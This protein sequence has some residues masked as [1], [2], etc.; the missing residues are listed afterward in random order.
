[1]KKMIASDAYDT[2]K[3]MAIT[4]E[5]IT[6][7]A[8]D[9][10]SI[11]EFGKSLFQIADMFKDDMTTVVRYSKPVDEYGNVKI[12]FQ[13]LKSKAK[14]FEK[15]MKET[16]STLFC[17]IT[18]AK[19]AKSIIKFINSLGVK[20]QDE[21]NLITKS[22]DYSDDIKNMLKDGYVSIKIEYDNFTFVTLCPT[23]DD[24]IATEELKEYINHKIESYG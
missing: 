7:Y 8:G 1:M 11:N 18:S 15:F 12:C 19:E 2:I 6:F 14:A 16:K 23:D 20:D 24:Y 22:Y 10:E 13:I 4:T 17:K 3:N 5:P 21:N 9:F